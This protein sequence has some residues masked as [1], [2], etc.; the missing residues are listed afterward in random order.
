MGLYKINGTELNPQPSN[1]VWTE[2]NQIGIDGNNRAI[3]APTRGFLI[4]WDA[5]SFAEYNVL[6]QFYTTVQSAG[7]VTAELPTYTGADYDTFTIYT[8]V[9]MDELSPGKMEF[10]FIFDVIMKLRNIIT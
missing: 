6:Y 4:R 8:D 9:V 5:L 10:K 2:R 1:G 3:Y 7:Y